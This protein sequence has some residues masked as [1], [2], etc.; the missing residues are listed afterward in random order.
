MNANKRN[1][2]LREDVWSTS[3]HH[4]YTY[5]LRFLILY[6]YEEKNIVLK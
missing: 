3:S 5:V 2:R 6:N 1:Q 4:V